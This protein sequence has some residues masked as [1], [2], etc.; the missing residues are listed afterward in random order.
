MLSLVID[1]LT[2]R[3][4]AQVR[5]RVHVSGRVRTWPKDLVDRVRHPRELPDRP[6]RMGE[7]KRVA[8]FYEG[9]ARPYPTALSAATISPT[10][11]SFPTPGFTARD[12]G[13]VDIDFEPVHLHPHTP[14]ELPGVRLL[15]DEPPGTELTLTWTATSE[16][17][18]GLASGRLTL[19]VAEPLPPA[20]VLPPDEHK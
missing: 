1:N 4:F 17:A 7:R 10:H 12:G 9:L 6:R 19:V 11:R 2:P 20:A 15:V 13:S 8:S 14:T 16:S 18:D 3:N 5:T